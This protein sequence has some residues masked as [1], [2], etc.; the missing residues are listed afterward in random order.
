[1]RQKKNNREYKKGQHDYF[2]EEVYEAGMALTGT[3]INPYVRAV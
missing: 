1:M 2:I 3:E